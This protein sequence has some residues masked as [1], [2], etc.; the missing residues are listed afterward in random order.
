M[1]PLIT[2]IALG[3]LSSVAQ[4]MGLKKYCARQIVSWLYKIRV[5][6]FDE[7][8]NLSKDARELLK[9]RFEIAALSTSNELKAKDGTRKFLLKTRDGL[10]VECVFIPAADG[11]NTVCIST[12]IGCAMGCKICRTAGMGLARNLSQGEIL[13]QLIHVMRIQKEPV[14]NV[15]LMGMGEPLSNLDAV[16]GAVELMQETVAFGMSKRRITL[17]T[18][19]LVP[20]LEKFCARFDIKIAISLGATTDEARTRLMPIGRRYNIASIMAF[21]RAYSKKTR[22]RVTFEYV[23]VAGVND[24]MEDCRRLVKLLKGVRAKV[25]L[26][27]FNPFDGC[28]FAAPKGGVAETFGDHL[29]SHGIQSNIR[30]SRGGEI[31][32]A[33]GQ[34]ATQ[35]T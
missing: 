17:S 34:L 29:H 6:S 33:C 30:A 15:V 12:Q 1:L 25:N 22:H 7:M 10:G 16:S 14:T 20:E 21:C 32:A 19:G 5:Q 9:Q 3:D 8:T 31:M 35:S 23:L 18:C 24:G 27:P 4:E 11:R 2:D 13:S 26:I 28:K